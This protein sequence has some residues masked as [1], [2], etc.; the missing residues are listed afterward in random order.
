M[1]GARNGDSS[2][3]LEVGTFNE[4]TNISE[5]VTKKESRPRQLINVEI[6]SCRTKKTTQEDQSLGT[7]VL[8]LVRKQSNVL[9]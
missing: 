3:D 4:N 5:W 2:K 9:L 1:I 7:V 8:V 6:I